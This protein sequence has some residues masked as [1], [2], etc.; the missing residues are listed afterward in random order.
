MLA[1]EVSIIVEIFIRE[2]GIGATLFVITKYWWRIDVGASIETEIDSSWRKCY[3]VQ[4]TIGIEK[5]GGF[6]VK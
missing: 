6:C 4:I 2:V 1:V 5:D 3:G